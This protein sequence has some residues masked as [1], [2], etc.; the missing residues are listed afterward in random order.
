MTIKLIARYEHTNEPVVLYHTDRG[1]TADGQFYVSQYVDERGEVYETRYPVTGLNT[2]AARFANDVDTL[3][4]CG[5]DI[6]HAK[7][8]DGTVL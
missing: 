5:I 8:P 3:A 7:F 1:L 2:S 4:R 6:S